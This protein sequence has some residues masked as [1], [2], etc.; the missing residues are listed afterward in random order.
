[1]ANGSYFMLSVCN[2]IFT[3]E[4]Q[5]LQNKNYA[6]KLFNFLEIC[7]AQKYSEP[8]RIWKIEIEM[9]KRLGRTHSCSNVSAANTNIPCPSQCGIKIN[10]KKP[11]LKSDQE[12]N[13]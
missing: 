5:F 9:Q 1:M 4:V 10:L 6:V 3:N 12:I 11:M 2:Y 8:T 13:Y 7:Q